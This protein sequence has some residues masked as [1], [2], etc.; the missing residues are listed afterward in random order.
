MMWRSPKS[1]SRREAAAG[2]EVASGLPFLV[3]HAIGFVIG[4]YEH[5]LNAGPDN[6]FTISPG[7]SAFSFQ[8]SAILLLL[9]EPVG[10]GLALAFCFPN[11]KCGATHPLPRSFV[12]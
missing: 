8:V 6:V 7:P 1:A 12:T 5:V 9:I 11:L 4:G 10:I 3:G 2:G